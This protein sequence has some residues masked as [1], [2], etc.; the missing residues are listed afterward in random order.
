[1]PPKGSKKR[2]A[3]GA[4]AKKPVK[5]KSTKKGKQ[6]AKA[7]LDA[8]LVEDPNSAERDALLSTCTCPDLCIM[9]P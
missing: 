6:W 3:G 1:M 8:Q 9:K 2:Q 7:Q 5:K 4:A